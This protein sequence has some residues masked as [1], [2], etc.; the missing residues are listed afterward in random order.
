MNKNGKSCK[1]IPPA[2]TYYGCFLQVM[3][4]MNWCWFDHYPIFTCHFESPVS[5]DWDF[6]QGD[7]LVRI[8]IF[9]IWGP[10]EYSFI[11][12]RKPFLTF[13]PSFHSTSP[14]PKVHLF[15]Y[16]PLERAS[17]PEISTEYSIWSYNK[18]RHSHIR[19]RWG[20][21]VGEKGSQEQ[22]KESETMPIS[23]A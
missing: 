8:F 13:V 17:P 19:A 1:W 20:N 18:T 7:N 9:S 21:P 3:N 16:F 14:F 11:R 2:H 22:A 5:Y 4:L 23:T 10:R 15:L 6:S 12:L